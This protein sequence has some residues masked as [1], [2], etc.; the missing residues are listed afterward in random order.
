[1]TYGT[2]DLGSDA[3]TSKVLR[4]RTIA[5]IS[6]CDTLLAR[7]EGTWVGIGLRLKPDGQ[8][9]LSGVSRQAV[10]GY[11]GIFHKRNW[12]PGISFWS[13]GPAPGRSK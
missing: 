8:Q 2:S 9:G 13:Y 5:R 1:M 7:L 3:V 11:R 10:W 4:N 12:S 6:S